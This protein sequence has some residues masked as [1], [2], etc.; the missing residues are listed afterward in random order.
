MKKEKIEELIE[1]NVG[2]EEAK[3]LLKNKKLIEE[4]DELMQMKTVLSEMHI[5]THDKIKNA[6]M[7]RDKKTEKTGARHLTLVF[8]SLIVVAFL[9]FFFVKEGLPFFINPSSNVRMQDGINKSLVPRE[10]TPSKNLTLTNNALPK[11]KVVLNKNAN[12][13]EAKIAMD[14]YC[15]WENENIC[16][17]KEE[18]IN[19]LVKE[20]KKYGEVQVTGLEKYETAK[21][22]TANQQ[23]ELKIKIDLSKK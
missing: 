4:F 3:K 2:R 5:P 19:A 16:I 1:K 10:S 18:K 6:V 14:K 15:K 21:R 11:I 7:S 13:E 20:L 12:E 9:S 8:A 17:I 22:D 23:K